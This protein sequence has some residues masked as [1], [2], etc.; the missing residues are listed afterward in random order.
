MD[1]L[2][3]LLGF[4][5]WATTRLLELS[6]D[7]TDAQMDQRF[8]LGLGT[9]RATFD[10]MIHNLAFWTALMAGQPVTTERTSHPSIAALS[11][12]HER[13]HA[14]FAALARRVRDAQRLDDTFVDHFGYRQTLGGTIL[15]VALHD[16]EHRTEALHMLKRLGVPD[17]P[18]LYP[19]DWEH[20]THLI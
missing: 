11:E 1:L 13:A 16:A 14:A 4:D 5:H 17:L 6:R 9:L 10:H 12:R 8:D 20:A 3:R 7:L 19:Q 18:E 15:H 2:D